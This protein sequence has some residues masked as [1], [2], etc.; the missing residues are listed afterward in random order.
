[1][2]YSKMLIPTLREDPKD[3]EIDSHKLMLRAGLIRKSAAGLY[4]YLPLGFRALLKV[5]Q[6]VREEMNSA[7]ALEILPPFVTPAELWKE[8]GRYDTMGKEMLRFKDRHDNEMVLGPTHEEAFTNIVRETVHSYRDLPVNLY[9]INTKFRDEIRPR[10]GVMRCREFIMKD[11]YSFDTDEAGLEANYQAMRTAYRKIFKRCGLE[12]DPV[13]ADTGSMGGSASEEFMVPSQVGEELIVKCH[14]C[15]YVANTERAVAHREYSVSGDPLLA[16]AEK[17][18]PAVKTIEE[19]TAFFS[20]TPDKFIKTLVYLADGAPVVAL[21][22]GDMEVNEVKLKNAAGAVE[23]QLAGE[24]KVREVTGAPV[25]FAGPVGLKNV[26]IIADISI[27]PLVNAITGANKKDLHLVN[28]NPGRDFKWEKAADIQSV[29][30]GD[31]CP[32]CKRPLN[33]YHGIEVGHIFKLGYKYTDAMN[34]IFLDKDGKEQK[35]IM[36]CYGIG[37]GRTMASVIEQSH[38]EFGIIWPMSIAPFHILIVPVNVMDAAQM[39][40]AEKL[41]KSLS[42]RYEVLMDDRDER[43]GVKFNDADLIGIPI[44]ITVG[45]SFAAEGKFELKLRN[46]KEKEFLGEAELI[47]RVGEIYENEMAGFNRD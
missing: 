18:T 16:I 46:S 42:S 15:G 25:G 34:V 17:E 26:R 33:A 12:V 10:Y 22:R 20:T 30:A 11:A 37:V 43:A 32:E 40:A 39:E 41:H 36:G 31:L 44:R 35:P 45:K 14:E 2:L 9:Q 23:L 8:T 1:M 28:V 5:T 3:A 47:K 13:L 24:E 21:I 4:S 6:I 29:Q 27:P 19:L 7:G 38:D